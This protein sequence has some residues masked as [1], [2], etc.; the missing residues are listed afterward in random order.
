MVDAE[1]NGALLQEVQHRCSNDLQLI[2][3]M[4]ELARRRSEDEAAA[5]ALSELGGRV[6]ALIH[7]RADLLHP[8]GKDLATALREL[9]EGL[10]TVAEPRSITISLT[11]ADEPLG[12]S[13]GETTAALLAVNELVT[14]AL[15][16]A[17]KSGIP[18]RVQVTYRR[19]DANGA[20]ITV[21]DSGDPFVFTPSGRSDGHGLGL[22]LVRRLLDQQGGM[23]IPPADGSKKFELRLKNRAM[24]LAD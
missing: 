9:C 21:E 23:L 4:I 5:A 24:A 1:M 12:V 16:H 11:I 13:D 19:P 10:Q 22:N 17:F 7:A 15:K 18:G 14:N 6:R 3:S 20:S 2:L 8:S